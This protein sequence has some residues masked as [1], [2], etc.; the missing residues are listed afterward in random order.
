M[1]V[2][3]CAPVTFNFHTIYLQC[4]RQRRDRLDAIY[5]HVQTTMMTLQIA[6]VSVRVAQQLLD[7]RHDPQPATTMMM[8]QQTTKNKYICEYYQISKKK[9]YNKSKY[10]IFTQNIMINHIT[11]FAMTS[12]I[13]SLF[14][15]FSFF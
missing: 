15:Y 9:I 7:H 4:H 11:T 14:G 3:V 6:C 12:T 2:C 13:R 5:E 10:L 1:F 8:M